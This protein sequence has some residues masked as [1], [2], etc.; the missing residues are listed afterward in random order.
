MS[1]ETRRQVFCGINSRAKIPHIYLDKDKRVSNDTRVTFDVDSVLA[2]PSN[3]AIAKRGIRWSPTRI[4]VSDLQSN[5][6]LRSV[7]VTYLDRNRKQHQVHRPMHQIPHYTFGRVIRFKDISLYLLFP[8]LYREEQTCSKLRDKDFQ[9]WIDSILLPAIYQCYSTAHV[10][11]YPSSYNH[12]RYNSTA[13]GVETLSRRVHT[14]AREQQLIYFLPPEAL[15]DMWAN[16]L[17]TV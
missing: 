6:H 12:S 14:V 5:L 17:A 9:L 10:Q 3:L 2:F 1:P 15:A 11:H 13:R 16:I 8:N 7:P 4:T